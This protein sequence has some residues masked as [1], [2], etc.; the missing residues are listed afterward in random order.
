MRKECADQ[1]E[2]ER[3]GGRGRERQRQ[4]LDTHPRYTLLALSKTQNTLESLAFTP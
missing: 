1:G 3:G 2:G 4:T